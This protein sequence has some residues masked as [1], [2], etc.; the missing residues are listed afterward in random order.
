M[1]PQ[2]CGKVLARA[3]G[4]VIVILGLGLALVS[5]LDSKAYDRPAV[6]PTPVPMP[7]VVPAVTGTAAHSDEVVMP[8][9][10]TFASV[11]VLSNDVL[12]DGVRSLEV[13]RAPAHGTAAVAVYGQRLSDYVVEYH[14]ADGF[15]G[16]DLFT[17]RVVEPGGVVSE[18]Q[19][20]VT[21][22]SPADINPALAGH[23]VIPTLGFD[24]PL[25]T[26][27]VVDGAVNPPTFTDAYVVTG[28][29]TPAGKGT[30]YVA[31][32]SCRKSCAGDP[33][34]DVASGSSRVSVGDVVFIDGVPY[35]VSQVRMVEK[36][37]LT[38][39]SDLWQSVDGRAVIFT[40]LQRPHGKSLDNVVII[41]ERQS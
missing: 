20:S 41:A 25:L 24:V 9:W 19:V 16:I 28:Y 4:G 32:H 37:E 23:L 6:V 38:A 36:V 26:M 35:M 22:K 10:L 29:G 33:L 8:V 14:P 31:M 34:I 21:V 7:T 12:P 15:T 39:Q 40:C 13:V 2:L 11:H 17:Y 18:A 5:P 30:T 27:A 3:L 1:I